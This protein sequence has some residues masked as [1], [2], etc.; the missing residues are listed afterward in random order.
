VREKIVFK[1]HNFVLLNFYFILHLCEPALISDLN[2]YGLLN[3]KK[4]T[5]DVKIMFLHHIVFHM[6]EHIL[7]LKRKEKVVVYYTEQIPNSLEILNYYKIEDIKKCLIS[8]LNKVQKFLPIRI[9]FNHMSF[10]E[11]VLLKEGEKAEITANVKNTIGSYDLTQFSFSRTNIF[12]KANNLSFL[13]KEYF[14]TIK[15]KQLL[16]T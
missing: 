5:K 6:C 10:S 7:K 14:N 8:V 16:L 13:N 1:E 2:R 15:T 9:H 3:N 11:V 12:T 4:I